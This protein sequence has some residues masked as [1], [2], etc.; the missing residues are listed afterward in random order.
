MVRTVTVTQAHQNL[1]RL[2]RD[3]SSGQEVVV[4]SR[5]KPVARLVQIDAPEGAE[6]SRRFDQ[7]LEQLDRLPPVTIGAWSRDELY[8]R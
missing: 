7:A 1:S 2:L 4:T 5:G 6:R 8:N 3:V